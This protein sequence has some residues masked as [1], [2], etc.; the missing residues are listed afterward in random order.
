MT[1]K[2]LTRDELLSSQ[3]AMLQE[4]HKVCVENDLRYYLAYGTLLGAVR[5][6]GFIPW[7]D[8]MDIMMPVEDYFKLKELYKSERYFLADCFSEKKHQ[9]YFPRIYDGKT[10][11]DGDEK[12][13]GVYIDIYLMHGAPFRNQ[14][15][16]AEHILNII[17]LEENRK[18]VTKWRGRFA[19]H[20]FPICWNQ[21][22]SKIITFFNQRIFNQLAKYEY[23]T[24]EVI[25][26][27]GGDGLTELFWKNCFC[28]TVLLDFEG[29]QFF[30]PHKYGEV[31]SVTYGD[32]MQLPPEEC[33]HPYH[34]SSSFCWKIDK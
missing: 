34:G 2:N 12:T 31:L 14:K 24:S 30:A 5:H 3:L 6:K 7:D 1:A 26:A 33:R 18:Q 13:L 25:Y 4:I 23:E 16:C 22:E 19:R 28:E 27:F 29:Y 11:R 9:A 17:K 15:K 21:Y 32:Y 20:M 8:D 10:C